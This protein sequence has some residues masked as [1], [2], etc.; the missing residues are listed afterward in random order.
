MFLYLGS[1]FISGS[2]KLPGYFH[3]RGS[4]SMVRMKS[5]LPKAM[6][7]FM[8]YDIEK[9]VSCFNLEKDKSKAMDKVTEQAKFKKTNI[10][11]F[12]FCSPYHINLSEIKLPALLA[13]G[14][15]ELKK[16]DPIAV[17]ACDDWNHDD[18]IYLAPFHLTNPELLTC[19]E[20]IINGDN[21]TEKEAIRENFQL[22]KQLKDNPG[23]TSHENTVFHCTGHPLNNV[24]YTHGTP[25]LMCTR[26]TCLVV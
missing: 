18:H 11:T 4:I 17:R 19:Y 12:I 1:R 8:M 3:C 15:G 16:G 14:V 2:V 25:L 21:A 22:L 9:F 13:W 20:E 24:C 6:F 7:D 23:S 5:K 10:S 26:Y